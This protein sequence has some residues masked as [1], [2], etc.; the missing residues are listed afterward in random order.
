V[1]PLALDPRSCSPAATCLSRVAVRPVPHPCGRSSASSA[2]AGSQS[3][4][5]APS[6]LGLKSYL[7][8]TARLREIRSRRMRRP[9]LS[10]WYCDGVVLV[11]SGEP[12]PVLAEFVPI[13]GYIEFLLHL[14]F[15][16]HL[17]HVI[18]CFLCFLL[19]QN[20]VFFVLDSI[21]RFGS[22][23]GS[24]PYYVTVVPAPTPCCAAAPKPLLPS[25]PWM[26]TLLSS[27]T[28]LASC[29][30]RPS[31]AGFCARQDNESSQATLLSTPTWNQTR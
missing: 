13:G 11:G 31:R 27:A 8:S 14:D 1:R 23:H 30:S 10:V 22:C 21:V 25:V 28:E 9:W 17:R 2:A 29:P 6:K 26:K 3:T 16:L 7:L 12:Q 19:D 15:I 20:G 18:L 24:D 4:A 5:I